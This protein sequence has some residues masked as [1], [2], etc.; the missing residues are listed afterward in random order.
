MQ[1]WVESIGFHEYRT[2]FLEAKLD[3]KKL[4]VRRSGACMHSDY[5][6]LRALRVEL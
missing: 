6:E 4:L 2:A 3:G 1:D 5:A